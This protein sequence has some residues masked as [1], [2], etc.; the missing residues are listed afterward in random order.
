MKGFMGKE[1]FVWWHGVVEDVDDPLFLGRC[2]VRV[3][4]FHSDDKI[5]LPVSS[6]PWAYPMQPITSAALSGIGTSPTGLLVG[7]HVFGFFR[8]GEEGQDPIM[9]GSFGGIPMTPPNTGK[10]FADPSGTYPVTNQGVDSGKFPLGVSVIGEPDTNRLAR[11]ANKQEMQASIAAKRASTVDVGVK[12][13]PGMRGSSTWSEPITP[14]SA[15][16]PKNQVRYTERG[17]VEEYDNTVGKERI[18]QYHNSG[19]F[20]EIGN[21]WISNPN[22]TRVQR[23]VGNDYE[24]IHGD[25]NIHIKG[26]KGLN[27]VVDGAVNITIN[28]GANVEVVGN[29][30]VLANGDLNLQVEGD[31]KASGKSIELYSEGDIGISGRSVSFIS[32]GNVMVMRQIKRV[33]VNSGPP[34]IR[35]KKVNLK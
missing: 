32:D 24:I 22:G 27:L 28:G 30:N 16:Y 19:T 8:D 23:V 17:H 26:S 35:P 15:V 33:E 6:L 21:G 14:Y 7:S 2:K 10:G 25:K 9:M 1:G 20:T 18:L 12:S 29:T 4:G 5:E 11:N 31:L 34:S 3:F 13:T